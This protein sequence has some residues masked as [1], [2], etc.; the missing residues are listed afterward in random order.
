MQ[1]VKGTVL[2]IVNRTGVIFAEEVS[3]NAFDSKLLLFSSERDKETMHN[4][5]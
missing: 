1:F 3:M 5:F 4:F 2:V